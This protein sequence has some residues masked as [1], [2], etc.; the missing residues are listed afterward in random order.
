[1]IIQLIWQPVDYQLVRLTNVH[2]WE[3]INY[4][5]LGTYLKLHQKAWRKQENPNLVLK[6]LVWLELIE[7]TK[8]FC[9]AQTY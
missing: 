2:G 7:L 3:T 5:R 1:M 8:C 4:D 9:L 6:L